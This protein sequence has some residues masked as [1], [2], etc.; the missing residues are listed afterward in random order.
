[1]RRLSELR[2]EDAVIAAGVAL[3]ATARREYPAAGDKAACRQFLHDNLSI[4]CKI[5]WVAFGVSQPIDFRYRRL[6]ARNPGIEVRSMPEMLYDVVR[7]TADHEARLPEN[8]RFTESPIIETGLDGELVLPVDVVYD[9]LLAIVG[10]GVNRDQHVD[11]DPTFSF[12]GG[13]VAINTSWGQRR[14]ILEF[15]GAAA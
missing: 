1:M 12:G 15:I 14:K 7:C 4:I 11:G 13:N 6:D 8:L 5:G 3:S 9:L 2:F 10:A